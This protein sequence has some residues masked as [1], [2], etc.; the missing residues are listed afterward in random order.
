MNANN[1]QDERVKYMNKSRQ[2]V[3][4]KMSSVIMKDGPR[5]HLPFD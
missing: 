2:T 1:R 4:L 5:G 3:D